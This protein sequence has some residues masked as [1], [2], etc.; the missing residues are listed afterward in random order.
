MPAA[1]RNVGITEGGHTFV[2]QP[3]PAPD[4]CAATQHP[5]ARATLARRDG[6]NPFAFGWRLR[7]QQA[8][9]SVVRHAA[10]VGDTALTVSHGDVAAPGSGDAPA[11]PPRMPRRETCRDAQK[12]TVSLR[13]VPLTQGAPLPSSA[14]P[15]GRGGQGPM[16]AAAARHDPRAGPPAASWPRRLLSTVKYRIRYWAAPGEHRKALRMTYTREKVVG[17]TYVFL[18]AM[19]S[20]EPLDRHFLE[21]ERQVRRLDGRMGVHPDISEE[22]TR[23][24]RDAAERMAATRRNVRDRM[25]SLQREALLPAVAG[26]IEYRRADAILLALESR[27]VIAIALY[28]D[29]L[30]CIAAIDVD[31]DAVCDAIGGIVETV[32]AREAQ[33]ACMQ[34]RQWLRSAVD[35]LPQRTLVRLQTVLSGH[36]CGGAYQDFR[37]DLMRFVEARTSDRRPV[38]GAG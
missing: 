1:D 6:W 22:S 31:N 13:F 11:P 32:L 18:N 25:L 24:L 14:S 5:R 20:D 8:A 7:G 34:R 2:A 33:T 36:A 30:R 3:A 38:A 19:L 21:L 37:D 28:G 15:H 16:V 4:G 26:S 35:R 10:G 9:R 29:A 23:V 12:E 17:A 27:I